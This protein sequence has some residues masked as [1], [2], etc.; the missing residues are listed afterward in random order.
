MVKRPGELE[1]SD[2]KRKNRKARIL[3]DFVVASPVFEK[4]D[5]K[6]GLRNV[7]RRSSDTPEEKLKG[8]RAKF[9]RNGLKDERNPVSNSIE[10]D[11]L[12]EKNLLNKDKMP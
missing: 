8:G 6:K 1:P 7:S 10:N 2:G 9:L 3:Y 4:I 5:S 11:S 12:H